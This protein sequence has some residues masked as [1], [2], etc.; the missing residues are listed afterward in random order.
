L[1]IEPCTRDAPEEYSLVREE[2]HT[3]TT[4]PPAAKQPWWTSAPAKFGDKIRGRPDDVANTLP[5]CYVMLVNGYFLMATDNAGLSPRHIAELAA[6]QV[7]V[8]VDEP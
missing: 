2:Q 5:R 4:D 3:D 7:A 1:V 6:D 8:S